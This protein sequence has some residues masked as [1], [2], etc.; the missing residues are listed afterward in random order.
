VPPLR[1]SPSL[2]GIAAAAF[3]TR[4]DKSFMTGSAARKAQRQLRGLG[5]RVVRPAQSFRVTGTIGPLVEGEVA[6][7]LRWALELAAVLLT[8]RRRV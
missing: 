7:A 8:E 2:T 3:D 1:L 5:C 6:R 4:A